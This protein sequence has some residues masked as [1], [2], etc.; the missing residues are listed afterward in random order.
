MEIDIKKIKKSLPEL[1]QQKRK[2]FKKEYGLSEKE[3]EMFIGNKRLADFFEASVSEIKRWCKDEEIPEDQWQRIIK[4]A[5][6]YLQTDLIGFLKLKNIKFREIK[7]SPENFAELITIL[8]QGKISS[9]AGKDILAEMIETG[10][11]PTYIIQERGLE[12]ISDQSQIEEIAEKIIKENPKAVEDYKKGKENAIQFLI[13]GIMKETKGKV[14]PEEAKKIIL[15]L[16][17]K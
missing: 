2:R 12:Q 14:N 1:P 13:G 7:V 8:W 4:I 11:D 16:I 17:N 3:I 5:S 15:N 9:R 6:N 10:A